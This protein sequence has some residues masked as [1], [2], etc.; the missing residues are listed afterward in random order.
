MPK[1]RD[2][3]KH[4]GDF[5]MPK[6]EERS[7]AGWA[8]I[9]EASSK[10]GDDG[11]ERF[12]DEVKPIVEVVEEEDGEQITIGIFRI[13]ED[14]FWSQK[15]PNGKYNH[16]MMIRIPKAVYETIRNREIKEWVE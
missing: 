7:L 16:H 13:N 1:D 9:I 10:M 4:R 11:N 5:L 14:V 6:D 12:N 2:S 3:D 15:L 8:R